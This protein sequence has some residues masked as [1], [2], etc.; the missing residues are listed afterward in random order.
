MDAQRG[1]IYP[2]GISWWDLCI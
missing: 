1:N 2:G